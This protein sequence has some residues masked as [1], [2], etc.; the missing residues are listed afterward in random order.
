LDALGALSVACHEAIT[1]EDPTTPTTILSLICSACKKKLKKYRE[2]AFSCLEK[3]SKR[4]VVASYAKIL[5][6]IMI[7]K[8][9]NN[10]V[11]TQHFG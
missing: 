5:R 10:A 6:S 4:L 1:K 9:A 3:V 8:T 11:L 2:S 7:S